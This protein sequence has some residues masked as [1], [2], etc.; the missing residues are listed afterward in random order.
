[1]SNV[2]RTSIHVTGEGREAVA[3]LFE[4]SA[5]PNQYGHAWCFPDCKESLLCD[6]EHGD[7]IKIEPDAILIRGECKS[8]PPLLL[9]QQL[10]GRYPELTF[11]VTGWE[12]LNC[13]YQKWIFEAGEGFLLDCVEN[14][15][16][17]EDEV[18]VYMR[19]GEQFLKL[20]FWVPAENTPEF[21]DEHD[22]VDDY[23][24]DG[25]QISQIPDTYEA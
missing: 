13:F 19:D 17:S 1:M 3:E 11:V 14:S 24:I 7:G 9:I 23:E 15:Y 10:S 4:K 12:P 16:E 25:K 5:I 20:P 8:K 22:K 6:R 18:V 21:R 2:N